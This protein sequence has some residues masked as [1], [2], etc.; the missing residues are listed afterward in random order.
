MSLE[1]IWWLFG[2]RTWERNHII[3]EE[4]WI[5]IIPC[6]IAYNTQFDQVIRVWEYGYFTKKCSQIL[7]DN[8][9]PVHTFTRLLLVVKSYK[10]YGWNLERVRNIS[11]LSN[12]LVLTFAFFWNI[13]MS[14]LRKVVSFGKCCWERFPPP[15]FRSVLSLQFNLQYQYVYLHSLYLREMILLVRVISPWL[16]H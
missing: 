6:Y 9:A 4:I 3:E 2:A 8:N 7:N 1:L 10:E 14:E 12:R 5:F 13:S 16:I 11:F 15:W